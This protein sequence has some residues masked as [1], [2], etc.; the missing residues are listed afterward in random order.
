MRYIGLLGPTSAGKANATLHYRKMG[1]D[2]AFEAK[3]MKSVRSVFSADL[4][5]DGGMVEDTEYFVS[6]SGTKELLKWPPGAPDHPH[7]VIVV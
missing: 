2:G 1:S 6:M 3:P 7:T 4:G 5:G